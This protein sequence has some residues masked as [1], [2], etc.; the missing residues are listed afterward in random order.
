MDTKEIDH[1]RTR[2]TKCVESI[3]ATSDIEKRMEGSMIFET[4]KTSRTDHVACKVDMRLEE[5]F[6]ENLVDGKKPQRSFRS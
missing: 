3:E 4:N 5:C 2:G 1:A 6:Q